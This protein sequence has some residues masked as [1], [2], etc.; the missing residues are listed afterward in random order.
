[1]RLPSILFVALAPSVLSIACVQ[2]DDPPRPSSG[3]PPVTTPYLAA[4][5]GQLNVTVYGAPTRRAMMATVAATT[6]S[7]TRAS[8]TPAV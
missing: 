1:M 5:G 4:R 2:H 6:S 7:R 3:S 8:S